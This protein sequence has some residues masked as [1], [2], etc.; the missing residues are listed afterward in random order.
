MGTFSPTIFK[1]FTINAAK[2]KV[3]GWQEATTELEFHRWTGL[4][5]E[6][7]QCQVTIG[8]PLKTSEA[9]AI[10]PDFAATISAGVANGA[11]SLMMNDMPD[12]QPGIFCTKLPGIMLTMFQIQ[13]PY[14]GARVTK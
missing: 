8:M 14:L 10:S 2:G 9:G 12:L 1:F 5:P 3:G 7:W 11:T 6:K 13:Y 4:W